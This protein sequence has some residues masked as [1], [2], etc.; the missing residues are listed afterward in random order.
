MPLYSIPIMLPYRM[1]AHANAPVY[2]LQV[3]AVASSAAAGLSTAKALCKLIAFMRFGEAPREILSERA[4]VG[5]LRNQVIGP[6]IYVITKSQRIPHLSFP[7]R[8]DHEASQNLL[9]SIKGL[10]KRFVD[11]LLMDCA[12]LTY[13][14]S[15][16]MSAL[17]SCA[18]SM[19]FQMFRVSEPIM[20]ILTLVGLHKVLPIHHDITTAMDA[21]VHRAKMTESSNQ[22]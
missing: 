5:A 18:Q 16:S 11:G 12:P 2:S 9:E 22:I 15:S 13:L 6:Y 19:N 1:E 7:P 4:M 17:N 21:L 10:D 20:K 3:E 14:D 8:L